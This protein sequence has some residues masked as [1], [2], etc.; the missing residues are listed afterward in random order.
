METD[1]PCGI[2]GDVDRN[3]MDTWFNTITCANHRCVSPVD[4]SHIRAK[5]KEINGGSK[6][7]G[8]EFYE[9]CSKL[10][11]AVYHDC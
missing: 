7:E 5:A 6:V 9:M 10:L 11:E 4:Y 2:C 3:E 1:E 8:K